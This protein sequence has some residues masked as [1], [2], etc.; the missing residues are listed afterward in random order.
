MP[1]WLSGGIVG[2]LIGLAS[3]FA[4]LESPNISLPRSLMDPFVGITIGAGAGWVLGRYSSTRKHGL[5]G[6]IGVWSSVWVG[7][8]VALVALVTLLDGAEPLWLRAVATGLGVG[9]ASALA[10]TLWHAA[11]GE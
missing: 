10:E 5:V 9:V 11:S 2:F 8:F 7:V 4:G 3:L 1:G 6:A